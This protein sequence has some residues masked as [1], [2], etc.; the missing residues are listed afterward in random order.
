MRQ[1]LRAFDFATAISPAEKNE[2]TQSEFKDI[3]D[4]VMGV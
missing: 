3:Q 4:K 1:A 2:V